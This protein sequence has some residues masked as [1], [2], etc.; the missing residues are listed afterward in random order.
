MCYV[1]KQ[2]KKKK[3][4]DKETKGWGDNRQ[5]KTKT[6]NSPS[7][8]LQSNELFFFFGC[9]LHIYIYILES[10]G[11]HE[12]DSVEEGLVRLGRVL[13]LVVSTPT[14]VVLQQTGAV[15]FGFTQ[16][17]I[18]KIVQGAEMQGSHVPRRC[19]RRILL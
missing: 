2:K 4:R 5:D 12:V 14:V 11:G 1:C 10:R 9:C 6:Q 16:P 19:L 3:D 7:Q 8:R 13:L 17:L 18:H 15:I